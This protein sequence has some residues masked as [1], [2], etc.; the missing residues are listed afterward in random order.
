MHHIICD[1]ATNIIIMNEL[2]KYYN[3]E[4]EVE[5][6]DIQYS[7]YAIH[8]KEKKKSGKLDS[9]ISIY[10]EIFSNEYEIL[11]IPTKNNIYNNEY[12]VRKENKNEEFNES[13][14]VEKMIDKSTSERINEFIIHHNISKTALFIS[15]Y[16]YVLSKYSGQDTIYTSLMSA[17]RNNHYV[18]NMAGM[19]VSTLPL[20][21]KY[22]NEGNKFIEIIKENME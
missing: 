13:N 17:N 18:E 4:E 21:L 11:N 3:E 10:R 19:F 8:L 5:K 15:V 14:K 12:D 22:N 20:L 7:D 6:L 2:N 9:Q 16:G 1:G